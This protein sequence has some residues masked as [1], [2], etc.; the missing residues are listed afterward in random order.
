MDFISKGLSLSSAIKGSKHTEV[1]S[2]LELKH[3]PE[4]IISKLSMK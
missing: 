4:K 1:K 3:N 2:L